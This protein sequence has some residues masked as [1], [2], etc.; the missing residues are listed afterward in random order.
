MV[1]PLTPTKSLSS[2]VPVYSSDALSGLLRRTYERTPRISIV[3]DAEDIRSIPAEIL[4]IA[5]EELRVTRDF[6]QWSK[7]KGKSEAAL[8]WLADERLLEG[9]GFAVA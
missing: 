9:A 1:T 8:V 3:T 4:E 2:N 6:A 5:G 7:S